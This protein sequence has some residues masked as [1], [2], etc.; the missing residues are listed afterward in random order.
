[1][2][3][4]SA[5][6]LERDRLTTYC[7]TEARAQKAS[8]MY[9]ERTRFIHDIFLT[10][11]AGSMLV[12]VI[13]VLLSREPKPRDAQ[14]DRSERSQRAVVYARDGQSWRIERLYP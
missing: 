13:T 9:I 6:L 11:M 14:A 3:A 2:K 1:M 8:W 12:G 7:R 5:R 4:F 10:V